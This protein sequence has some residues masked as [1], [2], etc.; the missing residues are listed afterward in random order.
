VVFMTRIN[1]VVSYPLHQPLEEILTQM[2]RTG[3]F[4]T[5]KAGASHTELN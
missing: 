5:Y 3:G 1:F 4:I 2:S